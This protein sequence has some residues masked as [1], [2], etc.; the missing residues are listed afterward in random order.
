MTPKIS[1]IVLNTSVELDFVSKK[2]TSSCIIYTQTL[3]TQQTRI[4]VEIS[5]LLK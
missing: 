4:W 3:Q 5:R 2:E 1:I